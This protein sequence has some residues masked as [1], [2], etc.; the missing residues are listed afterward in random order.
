MLR[1]NFIDEYLI[2]FLKD[3]LR[4]LINLK[5]IN[6]ENLTVIATEIT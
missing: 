4:F 3:K 1:Y 2:L 5:E 6:V